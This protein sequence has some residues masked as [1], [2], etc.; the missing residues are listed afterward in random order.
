MFFSLSQDKHVPAKTLWPDGM[1]RLNM[2]Q[3]L[4]ALRNGQIRFDKNHGPGKVSKLAYSP[5]ILKMHKY[6]PGQTEAP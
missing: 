1:G 3:K 6:F 5:A 2:A 4:Q